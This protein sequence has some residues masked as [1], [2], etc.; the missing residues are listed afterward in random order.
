MVR[1]NALIDS[2][3]IGS[4]STNTTSSFDVDNSDVLGVYISGDSNSTDLDILTEGKPRPVSGDSWAEHKR[5]D[6]VDV[7]ATSGN[8]TYY[9]YDVRGLT[10]VRFQVT[11]DAG[12]ATTVTLIASRT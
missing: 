8:A 1:S 4:S 6:S 10:E 11:N 3:S 2:T 7:T 9:E 5:E 12:S